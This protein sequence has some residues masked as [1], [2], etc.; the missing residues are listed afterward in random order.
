[1]ELHGCQLKALFIC[2]MKYQLYKIPEYFPCNWKYK[3]ILPEVWL[4][5]Y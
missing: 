1:M 4:S 5:Q 2:E 3:N